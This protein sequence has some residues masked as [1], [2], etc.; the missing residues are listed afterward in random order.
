MIDPYDIEDGLLENKVT[1]TSSQNDDE[2]DT[3][4]EPSLPPIVDSGD[5]FPV[6]ADVVMAE[7]GTPPDEQLPH[8]TDAIDEPLPNTRIEDE[9]VLRDEEEEKEEVSSLVSL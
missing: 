4:Q 5:A 3:L 8:D 1:T 2:G 9:V 6:H 7:S